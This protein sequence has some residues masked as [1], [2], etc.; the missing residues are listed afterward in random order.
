MSRQ[1]RGTGRVFQTTYRDLKRGTWKKTRVFWIAYWHQGKEH[2]ESSHSTRRP[3]AVRLLKKRLGE[4][5]SGQFLGPDAD[6]TTFD[7]LERIV[8]DDYHVN[9]RK[10]K[11]RA[12]GCLKNLRARLGHLRARDLTLDRLNGYVAARLDDGVRPATIQSELAILN[13]ALHLAERA[14]KARRPPFPILRVSNVRSGFFESDAFR[15]VLAALPAAI[16]PL[17]EFAYHTGWRLGEILPLTWR[18]IDLKAGIIRLEPG[19]TKNDEGRSFP[20]RALPALAA[21]IERQREVTTAPSARRSGSSPGCS[22]ARGRPSG[23]SGA[24]GRRPASRPGSSGCSRRSRARPRARSV[25][26]ASSMTSGG[27]PCGT[28]SERGLPFGGHEADRAQ[29]RERLPPL[30]HRQRG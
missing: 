29:D 13:R 6:K 11:R 24:R 4:M 30:R 18:Q 7:D 26:R 10:T 20:F 9:A 22:I 23:T 28:W 21:L 5:G 15:A 27:P 14:G 19:T 25:P 12:E 8:L 2:R 17:V 3:D 16:Q 1:H